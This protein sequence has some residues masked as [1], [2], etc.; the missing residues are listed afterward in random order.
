MDIARFTLSFYSFLQDNHPLSLKSNAKRI[1]PLL[2]Q[3]IDYENAN[4]DHNCSMNDLGN[5]IE[6][7]DRANPK[8][9]SSYIV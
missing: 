2:T 5:Y 7:C 8:T 9:Y 6:I 4:N 3:E 1:S